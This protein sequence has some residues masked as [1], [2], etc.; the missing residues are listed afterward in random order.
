MVGFRKKLKNSELGM[1][2]REKFFP[3][4]MKHPATYAHFIQA[5]KRFNDCDDKKNAS[6]IN[7]EVQICKK[8]W[9]C[10]P[11]HYYM[12]DL[13][14]ADKQLTNDELINYIPHFFYNYLFLPRHSAQKFSIFAD[15]K[16]FSEH[17]FNALKISKPKTI[18]FSFNGELYN[19]CMLSCSYDEVM[20][21]L[22]ENN[23]EKIF[24]KPSEGAGGKGIYIFHK[25]ESGQYETQQN[26]VFNDQFLKIKGKNSDYII[27]PGIIQDP[28][29]SKIYP[30]SVN[31]CR[32]ITENK[33]G[34]IRLVC[35]IL[36]MGRGQSEVDNA[37]TGGIFTNINI[38]SGKFGDFAI[39]YDGEKFEMHP[40][41][42]FVFSNKGIS[43]WEEIKKYTKE[44]AGKLPFFTY[45]GWDIALTPRDLVVI[46]VNRSPAIDMME[47]TS[48]G[49]REAFGIDNPDY[50]W[51]KIGKK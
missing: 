30:R 26:I 4:Q 9:K 12:H 33:N 5:M 41:T 18:C 45:L 14:R 10:Y 39:S 22:L 44:S 20:K 31:T 21:Q 51:K 38:S 50:Y 24:V 35:A 28:E 27:Q 25:T 13:F 42:Q 48:G 40:D 47:K 16:I 19:S 6:Q 29:I 8:Y 2:I 11:Y 43:R 3:N 49:L 1:K 17:I 36:R 46:E 37:T 23:Y 32:I 34:N 15:N 7:L